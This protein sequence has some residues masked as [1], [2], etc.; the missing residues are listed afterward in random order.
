M[1]QPSARNARA[2]R[3][4]EKAGFVKT[5]STPEKIK[6]ECGGLDHHDSVLMIR[7]M[8]H[9]TNPPTATE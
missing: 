1:M 7:Q 3:A 2:L 8:D 6:I 9:T 5:D 4:Y